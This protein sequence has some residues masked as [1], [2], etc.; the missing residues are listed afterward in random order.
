MTDDTLRKIQRCFDDA[1][2]FGSLYAVDL[3]D[4]RRDIGVLPDE[5]V[6][7]ASVFKLP[8]AVAFARMVDAGELDPAEQTTLVPGR[9]TPGATGFAAM[10]DAVTVSWRDAVRSMMAVSDNAAADALVDVIGVARI[11][12]MLDG[13][14]LRSIRIVGGL[15]T[16]HA[17]LVEDFGSTSLGEAI[18]HVQNVS[19][20]TELA[21]FDP[22]NPA[23]NVGT[24]R[25]F[26]RLLE[27]VWHDR[28]ASPQ[29]CAFIREV[30]AQQVWTQRLSAAFPFDDVVVSG[31][32]GTFIALRHEVGVVEYPNGES[33]AVAVLTRSARARLILPGADTAIAQAAKLAVAALR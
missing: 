10:T 16:M 17:S 23:N 2:L 1:G 9:R 21:T 19:S 6:V 24:C 25:D 33:Y 27:A 32:T 30:M 31:K 15:R 11:Q 4:R 12:S 18:Q 7:L 26:A 29:Q 22:A 5:P 3:D 28:A 8:V 13:L 14:G 20:P